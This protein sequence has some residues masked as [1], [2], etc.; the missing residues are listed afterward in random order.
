M[1]SLFIR[2]Q[3]LMPSALTPLLD[4]LAHR[5]PYWSFASVVTFIF[6]YLNIPLR[7]L[8]RYAYVDHCELWF[9]VFPTTPHLLFPLTHQKLIAI[10]LAISRILAFTDDVTYI[11]SDSRSD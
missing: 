4:T 11:I 1:C 5:P 3:V 7:E 9:S 10:L 2:L 6:E 8:L